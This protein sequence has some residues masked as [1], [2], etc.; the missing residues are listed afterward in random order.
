MVTEMM[1]GLEMHVMYCIVFIAMIVGVVPIDIFEI[2][3]TRIGL[4]C[5]KSRFFSFMIRSRRE[6]LR[7]SY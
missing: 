6:Q 3:Q 1:I 5:S 4:Q 2:R 7:N